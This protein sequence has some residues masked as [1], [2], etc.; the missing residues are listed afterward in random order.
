M[1]P[2]RKT[3]KPRILIAGLGNLTLMDDGV[4]VHAI[5]EL[6]K[7]PPPG[8]VVAE[9]GTQVLGALHLFE[10][11]DK[12]LAIDAMQ[13]GGKPGT[14]YAFGT[15]N[16]DKGGIQVS[17]HELNLL[18]AL[19]FLKD[20]VKPEII[21]FGVEPEKIDYGLELTPAVAAALPELTAAAR[22]LV[23]R[24]RGVSL[25]TAPGCSAS[26]ADLLPY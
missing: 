25:R 1:E 17:L 10:W 12:V 14:V 21:I 24:W 22:D 8:A 13:A 23:R 4:G 19:N 6:Q 9:V 15:D 26:A 11:A 2:Q 3:R 16:V 7:N 20:Q 5:Q 18:A